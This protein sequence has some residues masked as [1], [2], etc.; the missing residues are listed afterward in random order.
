MNISQKIDKLRQRAMTLW[1]YGTTSVWNERKNTTK[2]KIIKTLN[3]SVRSFLSA[4][5]QSQACA[6]TYR[7]VLAI[8]PA[9]AMLFALGRG[10]GL[11]TLLEKELY[12]I[13]H[14][15]R[16]AISRMLAFVDSYLNQASEGV[17]VGIGILFLLWTLISLVSSVEDSFNAVWGV[18]EGRS[19]WRKITDYTAM[20]L[21]LPVLLICAGGLNMLLSSTLDAIFHFKFLT[22]LV[23]VILEAC[24]WIFTWLFFTAVYMLIPNVKVK[25]ANAFIAGVLAGTGFLALQWIFVT[26]QMYVSKYN[27]IYGS[28]S[29]IPLMLI[30]LQ[31]VWVITLAGA[32]L[33]YASQ[34]IFEFDF[35]EDVD[36]ISLRYREKVI[37]A[38][39]VV[40]IRRFADS[41]PPITVREI[42]VGY[43]LP[44]RL[45]S[46]A[47][48]ALIAS[49]LISKVVIDGPKE[50]YGFQPA[51]EVDKIT[52]SLVRDRLEAAGRHGFIPQ[53]DTMFPGIVNT[54]NKLTACLDQYAGTVRLVDLSIKDINHPTKN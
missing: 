49:G 40:V 2:V 46:N 21:I 39:A 27:A 18:K 30:W 48:D 20:L 4:D 35:K 50:L 25:F 10:F 11:Q 51:M 12:S 15:Q 6:M 38:V 33:C 3:L 9:L 24:S 31:L 28:V 29:F 16:E 22:P 36:R 8:V 17:F 13:F 53:F 1:Q 44:S 37:M 45:V 23:T 42:I 43:H 7:T 14:A 5:I 47:L 32:V 34:N 19:I 54:Y 26:G 52:V 41:Q